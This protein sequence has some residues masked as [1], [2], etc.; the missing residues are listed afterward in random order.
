MW[1]GSKRHHKEEP[2]G[3]KWP[4][5]PIKVPGVYFTYDQKLLKENNFIERL[6]SIKKLINTWSA[7][8]LSIY[9]KMTNQ[10]LSYLIPKYIY[11]CSILSTPKELLK[12]LNKIVFKFLWK[13]VDKVTRA[14][15]ITNT[16][17]E[18]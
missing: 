16:K 9:D 18:D 12:E 1:I 2:L 6:D 8:G 5:E 11:I 4:D 17:R 7:R 14:S 13:G 3:I 15:V 10:I